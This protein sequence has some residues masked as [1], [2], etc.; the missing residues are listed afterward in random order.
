MNDII[1]I[2]FFQLNKELIKYTRLDYNHMKRIRVATWEFFLTE[3]EWLS[4][5]EDVICEAFHY[6]K[7][8][9]KFCL[10][11]KEWCKAMQPIK[12]MNIRLPAK[13][14][15][16]IGWYSKVSNK[17][18]RSHAITLLDYYKKLFEEHK[19]YIE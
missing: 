11:S 3:N 4:L 12:P 16:D 15:Y 5:Y 8:Y 17:L 1:K 2:I 18:T 10:V 6:K 7:E 19:L 14:Y 13:V 9:R